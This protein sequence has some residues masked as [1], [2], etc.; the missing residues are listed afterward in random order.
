MIK[1]LKNLTERCDIY[2]EDAIIS[3]ERIIEKYAD[4][5]LSG[6][7]DEYRSVSIAL[8]TGSVCFD[9]VSLLAVALGCIYLDSTNTDEIIASFSDGDIVLYKN[10]RYRWRGFEEV[11]GRQRMKLQQ[12]GRGKN[13]PS[14][15]YILYESGRGLIKPYLG[16]SETTDGRGIRKSKDGRA[17]FISYF[18]GVPKA[19]VPSVT[20]VSTVIVAEREAFAR[21]AD[22]LKI[23]YGNDKTMGLLDIITASYFT[24]GGEEYRYG[25]NP[26]KTEPN[27]KITGRISTAR[28]L[29]LDKRGNPMVG[30]M[31][32]GTD[33][34]IKGDSE[35]VDLLGRKSIKFAHIVSDVDFGGAEGIVES[36]PDAAI[37]ACTKEFLLNNSL[38]VQE[39]SALTSEIDRQIDNIL[40]S[41]V[42]TIYINGGCTWAE[43]KNAKEAL[44]DIKRS[45]MDEGIKQKFIISAYSLLNMLTTATFPLRSLESA[46]VSGKLSASVVSPVGRINGLWD[47]AEKSGS[48]EY[49]CALVAD[50]IERFYK[51]IFEQC[52]KHDALLERLR[53]NTLKRFAIIV[54]KVYYIDILSSNEEIRQSEATI[55]TAN[56]FDSSAVYDEIIAVGDIWGKRFNPLRCRAA[57]DIAVLLYDCEV[58]T[59]GHKARK[60]DSFERKLNIRGRTIEDSEVVDGNVDIK[61]DFDESF[62]MDVF[63]ENETDFENY[64][65]NISIFDINKFAARL[66]SSIGNTPTSEVCVVGRF[67]SGEQILFSKYY[68]AVVFEPSKGAVVELSSD[69]LDAG[70]V[71]IF[72]KRDDYTR[73]MVDYLYEGLVSGNKLNKEVVD[74]TEKAF[75]WKEALREYRD[76]NRLSYKALATKF[77]EL[78]SS[79]QEA[80]IRHWLIEES[81]IVG[82]RDEKTLE[83]IAKLTGDPYL[84][85]DTR[86]YFGACHIVRRQRKE[87]LRLI[88]KAIADRLRGS[89][90]PNGSLLE[91]IYENIE[92]LSESFELESIAVLDEP[93]AVPINIVNKPLTEME[94]SL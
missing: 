9:A 77:R 45:N 92:K 73:N 93:I 20:S 76:K 89:V 13:G 41:S 14:E 55:V 78:G 6:I 82:P 31:I 38:P 60:A 1:T 46:I 94:A 70:N 85:K 44:H 91:S 71:L 8:H 7:S 66:L 26:A 40:N 57:E 65:D 86:G 79:I 29:A 58:R 63:I 25:S 50:V 18:F 30:L 16:T 49:T 48:M 47:L 54:P 5:F 74:A 75:Y 4:F 34:V 10:E 51:S 83:Y 17:D 81:H 62:N 15:T 22:G 64:I 37:F 35:L 80:S 36:Q 69:K 84:V 33:T 87:I 88:S 90:P 11:D 43:M 39:P 27:L 72:A 53:A 28:N 24:D 2:F 32:I 56:R 19:E 67:V 68:T 12:D 23:K 3:K 52:P 21:I 42:S 61:D 59:F